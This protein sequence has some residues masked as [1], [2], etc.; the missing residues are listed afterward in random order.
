MDGSWGTLKTGEWKKTFFFLNCWQPLTF[1][2]LLYFPCHQ[3][4]H[5]HCRWWRLPS[6]R[7]PISR[8]IGQ[9]HRG[10]TDPIQRTVVNLYLRKHPSQ[11]T[12]GCLMGEQRKKVDST[13]YPLSSLLLF[14]IILCSR[15]GL[16]LKHQTKPFRQF[17]EVLPC[18]VH[19]YCCQDCLQSIGTYCWAE[20]TFAEHKL[21]DETKKKSSL[22]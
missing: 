6:S 10:G 7:F 4:T 21:F 16:F 14:W 8:Q 15:F 9:A 11:E 18:S 1:L 5:C 13:S 19:P 2:Q 22:F 12:I 3:T 17:W 20:I